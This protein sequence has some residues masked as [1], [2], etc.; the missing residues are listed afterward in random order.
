VALAASD[1]VSSAFSVAV[2]GAGI[3]GLACARALAERGVLP[4]VFEKS[5][6]AG[7]RAAARMTELG[8]FDHGVQYFTVR[9]GDFAAALA[10]LLAA[11]QIAPW[12]ARFR[13][14]TD[15]NSE[16]F[17][18][19][20]SMQA[21]GAGLA[22]GI[23]VRYDQRVTRLERV[24]TSRPPRWSLNRV[25][26][27]AEAHD[28]EVTE[29]LFDALVIALPPEDTLALLEFAP[30]LARRIKN[31]RMRPCWALML[32]FAEPLNTPFDA[33]ALAGPR[34][35]W[36]A[37]DSSKPGRRPGERWV[38]HASAAWSEEHLK[39]DPEDV[40]AKLLKAFHEV[41]ATRAQPIHA[42]VHRWRYS[43]VENPLAEGFVWD[44]QQRVGACGDW[45][46]GARVESAFLSGSSLGAE[47]ASALSELSRRPPLASAL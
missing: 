20:P 13:T 6:A 27:D 31:V 36:I 16:R 47:V 2:V 4:T 37:R 33:A 23:D 1:R 17:V 44:A 34:L 39:D 30:A 45:C 29:G 3:S 8:G 22:L 9:D 15:E 35:S 32:G 28:L 41:T 26:Y 14:Q 18:G 42:V 19:V 5:L 40:R 10:P 38:A 24:Y 46:S 43:L 21:L 12:M 25:G 7:G 11:G